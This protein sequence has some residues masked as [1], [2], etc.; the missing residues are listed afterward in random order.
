MIAK[1]NYDVHD[2]KFLIIIEIFKEWRY[3]FEEIQHL[4][5]VVCDYQNLKYFIITKALNRR[6]NV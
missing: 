4:I 2:I 5:E 1:K 6:Q 3:Y